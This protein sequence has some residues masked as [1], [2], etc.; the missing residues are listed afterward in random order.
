MDLCSTAD[1]RHHLI[2]RGGFR[3][4]LSAY[5]P[6]GGSVKRRKSQADGCGMN[7]GDFLKGGTSGESEN[8]HMVDQV[9]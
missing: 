8:H 3:K 9:A 7:N 1:H 5:A 6:K 2:E 4:I